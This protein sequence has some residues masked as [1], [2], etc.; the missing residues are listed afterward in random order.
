MTMSDGP[1][2]RFRHL[3]DPIQNEI[4]K[5]ISSTLGAPLAEA[6]QLITDKIRYIRW[7][8]AVKT[9]EK[10]AQFANERNATLSA[11]HL[12]FFLPFMEG[13]SLEE[14]E[15]NLVDEWARLLANTSTE[16]SSNALIFTRILRE[17][18]SIE[19][20][21]MQEIFQN[22]S[23]EK[24]DADEVYQ[25][26]GHYQDFGPDVFSYTFKEIFGR[27]VSL[28]EVLGDWASIEQHMRVNF[29]SRGICL[30]E[31]ELHDCPVEEV[32]DHRSIRTLNDGIYDKLGEEET[33]FAIDVLAYHRLVEMHKHVVDLSNYVEGSMSAWIVG[34]NVTSL[35]AH[36][37][38][39]CL[40]QG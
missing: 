38:M 9:L 4:A 17:I 23:D 33:L 15:G 25:A 30:L 37:S 22:K 32:H 6:S 24:Q 3:E 31:F 10:A 34:V 28:H 7:K 2:G 8:N 18:G 29:S 20:Q 35:G 40:E 26:I 39:A 5:A 1:P 21:V 27:K 13:C 14:A 16:R 36:F 11:P 12:K 19:A